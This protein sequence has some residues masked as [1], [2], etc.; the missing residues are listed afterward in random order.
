MKQNHISNLVINKMTSKQYEREFNAGRISDD[1]I[2]LVPD[3]AGSQADWAQNDDTASDYVKNRTHYSEYTET[4]L[5][6]QQITT[7][8]DGSYTVLSAL[9]LVP[10]FMYT[11]TIDGEV[12]ENL[13]ATEVDTEYFP[14]TAIYYE[15]SELGRKSLLVIES[16]DP[17]PTGGPSTAF[18]IQILNSDGTTTA[19][20]YNVNISGTQETVHEL[21]MKY[22]P[23][24]LRMWVI[25]ENGTSLR[26]ATTIREGAIEGYHLGEGAL[27]E[28][29]STQ[30]EGRASHAEGEYSIASGE[31]SHAEGFLSHAEGYASHAE[32]SSDAKGSYSHAE[33]QSTASGNS[34]HTEGK[35]NIIDENDK[36]VHIVGNGTQSGSILRSNAHTLDW[37]GLGWFAS[38][39]KVG[40]TGQDDVNAK[41]LAT[42]EYVNT[43]ELITTADIDSLWGTE[44]LDASDPSTTF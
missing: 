28:G 20:T 40:G 18:K 29:L 36:Y 21:N 13:V 39:V 2:Y 37:N 16:S 27:A 22:L 24:D 35:F 30:V 11:V 10:G 1:E 12:F 23:K 9:G 8:G 6:S 42:E 38:S 17:N 5:F 3:E 41:V 19:S 15:G 43:A 4:E 14:T 34:Q 31:I 44:L 25:G 26:M 33:G 32:G 7:D